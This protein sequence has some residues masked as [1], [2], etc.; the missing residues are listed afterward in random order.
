M[1]IY[2]DPE[3]AAILAAKRLSGKFWTDRICDMMRHACL[4]P[5]GDGSTA[6]ADHRI[7]LERVC[8]KWP[9]SG[10][11]TIKR[12]DGKRFRLRMVSKTF[13]VEVS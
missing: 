11:I 12:D 2:K 7:K 5:S 4:R 10:S 9:I 3:D 8:K 6:I 13:K 1:H